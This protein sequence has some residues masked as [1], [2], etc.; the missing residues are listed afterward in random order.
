[1]NQSSRLRAIMTRRFSC[2]L[3][4]LSLVIA[5]LGIAFA[6]SAQATT[7]INPGFNLFVT[8]AGSNFF[9]GAPVPNPQFVSFEGNPVGAFDFGSGPVFT[10]DTDTIVERTQPANLGGGSDTIDIEIVA[11]S[12]VS[13]SPVDLGFGA[14]FED[15]FI[16]LNTSSPTLQSTM[17]IVDAGEGQPHG[18]F[19][20]TLNFS[21]DVV[22]SVGG[23]YATL[24]KTLTATNQPWQHEPTAPQLIDGVNHLLNTLDETN[25]FWPDGIVIHDDGSGT[26]IHVTRTPEPST[27]MLFGLGAVGLLGYGWRRRRRV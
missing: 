22:G 26:A 24:E 20:S 21:F 19:D 16:N 25:D 7:I 5:A 18:T 13:V 11:L 4:V 12:L 9:F 8:L 27:L 23:F 3:P 14:G 17:T 15:M 10:G 1:M 2:R 6:G